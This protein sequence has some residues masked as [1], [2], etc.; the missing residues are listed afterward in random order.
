[1]GALGVFRGQLSVSTHLP[2]LLFSLLHGPWI[3]PTPRPPEPWHPPPELSA[4]STS[5]RC[6]S[7]F[8][9]LAAFCRRLW[10]WLPRL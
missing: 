5:C 3:S 10:Y 2:T 8:L 1:M 4:F 7:A 6:W 9:L